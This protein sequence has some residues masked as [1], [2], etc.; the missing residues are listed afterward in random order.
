MSTSPYQTSPEQTAIAIGYRNTSL[1]GDR[2]MPRV[3]VR[4]KNF[5]Y[6]VFDKADGFSVPSTLVGRKSQ[7]NMVEFGSRKVAAACQDYGLLDIIPVD[8]EAE[9]ARDNLG[10]L[11]NRS[12]E[13][14]TALIHLDREVRVAGLAFDPA[15]YDNTVSAKAAEK[16]DS[17]DY[18]P[19]PQIE[20]YLRTPLK[21]PNVAVFGQAAWSKFRTNPY[22]VKAAHGN[23]GDAGL[24]S[25]EAVRQM[26]EVEEL[27]V[28]DSFVNVAKPGRTTQFAR[29]WGP[30]VAFLYRGQMFQGEDEALTWGFTGQFGDWVAGRREVPTGLRGGT[31]VRVGETVAE[32]VAAR[33]AGFLLQDVI[34]A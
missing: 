32:V 20:D 27:L 19:L 1:I 17:A 6:N 8:D 29:T 34:S 16:F 10:S 5:E 31:E 9:A 33:G 12:T 23:S 18:N 24:A 3:P 14:L 11:V 25:R 30:H 21:R 28:G 26:L 4:K 22:V 15:N 13:K 2:V 7:P